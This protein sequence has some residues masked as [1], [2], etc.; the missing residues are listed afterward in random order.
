MLSTHN[1]LVL[2]KQYAAVRMSLRETGSHHCQKQVKA[3]HQSHTFTSLLSHLA[4]PAPS[5]A[6]MTLCYIVHYC[7]K[8]HPFWLGSLAHWGL[9]WA[10]G[11]HLYGKVIVL[12]NAIQITLRQH[13][14][15]VGVYGIAAATLIGRILNRR[16]G[17]EPR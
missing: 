9:E 2:I 10:T 6:H 13:F 5:R 16:G 3:Q 12:E 14:L 17:E 11:I 8:S 15:R 7:L 4:F 1:G